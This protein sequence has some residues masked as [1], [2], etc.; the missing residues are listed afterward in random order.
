MAIT[1]DNPLGI[2]TCAKLLLRSRTPNLW[3]PA[4]TKCWANVVLML[5]Q[6]PKPWANIN[7]VLAQSLVFVG[8]WHN[9][10]YTW[11]FLF[12]PSKQGKLDQCC[13]NIGPLSS[14]MAQHWHNIGSTTLVY[15][16]LFS[17]AKR[18]NQAK[19]IKKSVIL[20]W[21]SFGH[22]CPK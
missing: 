13:L 20:F 7:A 22:V 4:N 12:F 16:V 3:S 1:T 2:Q 11:Y 18:H 17:S 8:S 14:T 5:G 6:C 15:W 21:L 19:I 10:Y 9:Y